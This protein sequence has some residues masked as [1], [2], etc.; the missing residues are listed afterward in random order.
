MIKK[1]IK[2]VIVAVLS[3]IIIFEI[4]YIVKINI[5]GDSNKQDSIKEVQTQTPLPVVGESTNKPEAEVTPEAEEHTQTPQ[6][7]KIIVIDPGHGKT[8]SLMTNSEKSASGWVKNSL[9]AWGEWRH[10]KRRSST[11]DCE[12]SGCNGRV[13][14]SGSC[15]YPIGNG[16]RNTEPDI[17]LKNALAAKKHLEE[18]G[19]TVRLTR[20]GNGEN[21][22]VTKRISYC[23]PNNDTSKAPDAAAFICLHSNASG[24][25]G[26]GTAYIAAKD[27]YDQAWIASDYSEK[28]NALGKLCNDNIV[29]MT[30]LSMHSNGVIAWEPELIAFCKSPVPCGYLEIGFFDNNSDLE[31]L[32]SESDNIG[33]AI[34]KG[35]DEFCK[36]Q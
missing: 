31:I 7:S 32:N 35:V 12:G 27:P 9:G 8:S 6:P 33:K 10:Y 18:M 16:D 4:G 14:P 36:T 11:V 24:G 2:P 23:Y 5:I 29:N 13:T 26:R 28:S 25:S 20:S 3:L 1:Y 15:W 30:S 34:A 17:N 21:P 19:Y 22:S